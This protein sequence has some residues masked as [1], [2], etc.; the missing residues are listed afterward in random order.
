MK[1]LK[2]G[3]KEYVGF[4]LETEEYLTLMCTLGQYCTVVRALRNDLVKPNPKPGTYVRRA[5]L[6]VG[7]DKLLADIEP[8]LNN[9]EMTVDGYRRGQCNEVK[10]VGEADQ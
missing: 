1:I 3:G 5:I 4:E 7:V 8:M 9:L 2:E 10:F 6:S